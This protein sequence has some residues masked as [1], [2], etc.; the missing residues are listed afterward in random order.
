M[1]LDIITQNLLQKLQN[2]NLSL[3]SDFTSLMHYIFIC[4][5][6]ECFSQINILCSKREIIY[7]FCKAQICIYKSKH[8]SWALSY[9]QKYAGMCTTM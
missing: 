2:Q 6:G 1:A 7:H 5:Q 4:V 3:C 8:S 9:Q